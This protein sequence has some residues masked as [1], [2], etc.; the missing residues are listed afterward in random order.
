LVALVLICPTAA[1]ANIG[2]DL[3]QLRARY[4]GAKE[5]GGQMLFEHAG[6]SITVYFDGDNSAMEIFTKT[7]S[8]PGKSDLSQEDIDRILAAEGEGKSWSPI[9][10]HSGKPTW[11]RADGKLIARFSPNKDGKA[12]DA[13]VL[14]IMLNTK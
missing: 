12:D 1:W 9:Q 14:V 11:V 13:A 8:E 5:V 2:E 3:S 10:V 7:S 4:G 6:F